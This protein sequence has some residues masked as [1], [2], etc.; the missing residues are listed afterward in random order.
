[1]K[2]KNAFALRG[3]DEQ[4]FLQSQLEACGLSERALLKP[5]G[6]ADDFDDLLRT[7]RAYQKF[8]DEMYKCRQRLVRHNDRLGRFLASLG[9]AIA[10]VSD[11]VYQTTLKPESKRVVALSDRY[12]SIAQRILNAEKMATG[13]R[14]HVD[15]AQ[16]NYC[17]KVFATRLKTTRQSLGLTQ[18]D[19]GAEFGVSKKAVSHYENALREPSLAMLKII[20]QLSNRPVDW[21]LSS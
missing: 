15:I 20:S 6:D 14:D 17:L 1:M 12:T 21:F 3:F 13:M 8:C 18:A 10:S 5:D 7:R 4:K 2:T 11:D 19:L 16:R 9:G